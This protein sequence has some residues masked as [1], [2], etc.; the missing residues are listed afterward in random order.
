MP[1]RHLVTRYEDDLSL[2]P[3]RWNRVGLVLGLLLLLVIPFVADR[4]WLD[5]VNLT[6]VYVVGA[7]ALVILT[8]FTGQISLGHF[9]IQLGV[10]I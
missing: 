4:Y 7:V 10:L 1:V 9:E 3:T 8:G 2:C 5:V 6:A